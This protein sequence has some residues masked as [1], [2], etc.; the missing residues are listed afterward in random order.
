MGFQEQA[1]VPIWTCG[2]T[3][4]SIPASKGKKEHSRSPCTKFRGNSGLPLRLSLRAYFL[5]LSPSST[6][7]SSPPA[8]GS[9][10][11]AFYWSQFK[12]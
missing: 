7:E 4:L 2:Q 8:Q 6:S 12:H 5:F 11:S 3:T 10:R 9:Y 1:G